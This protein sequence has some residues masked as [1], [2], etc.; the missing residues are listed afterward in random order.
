M[1]TEKKGMLAA[2]VAYCIFGFSYLFAKMALSIDGVEPMILLCSRSTVSFVVLN[3]LVFTK[4]FKINFRGKNIWPAILLGL[5]QPLIFSTLENY[6]VKFST[7]S[8]TGLIASISPVFSAILGVFLLREKP[9]W[10][11]WI[12]IVLSISGVMMVSLG[13]GNEGQ[14]TVIGCVCLI[15][16]YLVAALYSILSR[17]LSKGFTSVELTYV[18]FTVGFVGFSSMTFATYRGETI[19][20]LMNAWSHDTFVIASLYL[21]ILSAIVAYILI[22]YAVANLPVSRATIFSSFTTIISVLS[23]VIIM[24]DAFGWVSVVAFILILF[25]VFGVNQFVTKGK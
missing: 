1:S 18:M 25:G 17:K 20:M 14:N 8:F 5:L 7:T 9:N 3:L 13:G 21:G 23:G 15:T 19:P 22:N 10:K 16:A 24:H 12:C 2:T 6:G 4:V 11:Q